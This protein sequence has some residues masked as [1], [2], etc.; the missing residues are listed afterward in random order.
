VFEI[1]LEVAP[2]EAELVIATDR[3]RVIFNTLE[4]GN[5]IFEEI[6]A[7]VVDSAWTAWQTLDRF[8]RLGGTCKW[9]C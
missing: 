9:E 2:H 7:G 3:T 4:V 6:Y 1:P 8:Y 5:R